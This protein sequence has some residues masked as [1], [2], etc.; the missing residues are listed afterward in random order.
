MQTQ[1]R[2]TPAAKALLVLSTLSGLLVATPAV[3]AVDMFMTI[4][5]VAGE[6][7]DE[8]YKGGSDVL[9]W[10]WGASNSGGPTGAGK[11][12][13]QDL[14]WTQYIDASIP[15][16]FLGL[17][18]GTHFDHA[19]L[20]VRSAGE[21]RFD[22]LTIRFEN[23]LITSLS[24]GG[25]GGEARLT[26]NVTMM[27]LDKITL[28]YTPTNRDG[29]GGIPKVADWDLNN[30]VARTFSGDPTAVF[31]LFLAGQTLNLT[32]LPID[33]P[34]P[35]PE[36]QTWLMFGLG[37]AGLAGWNRRRTAAPTSTAALPA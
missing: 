5:S 12:S 14:S 2:L 17:A 21:R 23:V 33:L 10:S 26:T 9:A 4:D 8:K 28:T 16:L 20:T 11:V 29:S 1:F 31:G 3:A 24:M 7:T 35:I 18:R 27:P 25:S 22:F 37:L 36:P 13:F 34:S 30:G 15:D 32:D 19:T 6:S